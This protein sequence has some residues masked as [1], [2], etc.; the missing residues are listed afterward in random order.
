MLELRSGRTIQQC[1]P[2][3]LIVH[4]EVTA[5]IEPHGWDHWVRTLGGGPFHCAAWAR[6]R[7]SAPHKQPLFFAWRHDGETNPVAIAL[8]IDT[9]LPRPVRARSIEFDA[10]PATRLPVE[11]LVPTLEDWMSCEPGVADAW[12]GSFDA[13]HAW[14]DVAQPPTRIEFRADP[15]APDELLTRMRTLARRSV[16]RAQRCGVEIDPDSA[17]LHALVELY[18]ETLERLHRDKCVS[19]IVADPRELTTRLAELRDAGAARLFLAS[20]DGIPVAGALFTAFGSRAFYLSGGTSERGR[21][22]GAMT[23]VLYRAM[24]EFSAAGYGSINLG[25]ASPDSHLE[26][27]SDHGLY[28]FKCGMGAKP[29]PCRDAEIVVRP[30]RRRLLHAAR[31]SRLTLMRL[32]ATQR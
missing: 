21:K 24:C 17:D 6:Y 32:R 13:E 7:T 5:G 23:A 27:S 14:S 25:G 29:R 3:G 18:A 12:L 4:L 22:T 16:R 19:T 26:S 11:R 8:G 1:R 15:A 20:S 28:Q 2:T 30:A 10:P 9:G 31:A